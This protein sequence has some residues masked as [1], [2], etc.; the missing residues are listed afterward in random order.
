MSQGFLYTAQIQSQFWVAGWI[1]CAFLHRG[2]EHYL[3][4][5]KSFLNQFFAV[6]HLQLINIEQLQPQDLARKLCLDLRGPEQ[7]SLC[8]LWASSCEGL[9]WAIIILVP[10]SYFTFLYIT[11][12]TI[13]NNKND[14]V[15][16]AAGGRE[17]LF[18]QSDL[19]TQ[20]REKR[21]PST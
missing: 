3:C 13:N 2:S 18:Q 1:P 10:M 9:K 16:G 7:K 15:P 8:D 20:E 17:S 5:L 11:S 12:K 4:F 21:R 6:R 14:G 19:D